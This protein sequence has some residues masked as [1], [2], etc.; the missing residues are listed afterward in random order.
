ML[1]SLIADTRTHSEFD[2][3]CAMI[4]GFVF[5][6]SPN[7]GTKKAIE[8]P[9][10]TQNAHTKKNFTNCEQRDDLLFF[11]GDNGGKKS[12]KNIQCFGLIDFFFHSLALC[13]CVFPLSVC[14]FGWHWIHNDQ[15]GKWHPHGHRTNIA[16]WKGIY[17][18]NK[19]EKFP[20]RIVTKSMACFKRHIQIKWPWYLS[21]L[22][23]S[24][25]LFLFFSFHLNSWRGKIDKS[26]R[27]SAW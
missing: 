18:T 7:D 3:M 16:W 19:Y 2:K 6:R 23:V 25:N 27:V 5:N 20:I 9:S 13:A 22:F 14:R 21:M 24:T 17:R 15:K 12:R 4:R 26:N 1:R 8:I 10:N 11:S